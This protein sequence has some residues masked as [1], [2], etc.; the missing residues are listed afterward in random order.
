MSLETLIAVAIF[1]FVASAT[2]GP[3]NMMLLAS[4]VNFGFRRTIPHMVGI[5]FG[6]GVLVICIGMGLG[7]LLQEF[8]IL[9]LALKVAG[10]GYLLYLAFRIAL[11]RSLSSASPEKARPMT[12]IG[13]ALFQ[14]V[15]PKAW[16]MAVS[17]IAIYADKEDPFVSVL[18]IA[19]VFVII[20]FPSVS[21]WAGFGTAL[22]GFLA[23]PQRLKWFNI[24]TGVLLAMCIVP[25]VA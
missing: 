21:L 19:L 22:Q 4:G 14:W 6:F 10:G 13:A 25:M 11:S 12:L 5:A 8:P 17:A 23:H 15:N 20:N 9:E 1:A 3:N 18:F 7:A 2:P 24:G 16:M